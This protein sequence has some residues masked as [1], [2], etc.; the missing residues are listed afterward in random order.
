MVNGEWAIR[1]EKSVN[2]RKGGA[3][4]EGEYVLR[5]QINYLTNVNSYVSS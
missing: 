5:A 2:G 3:G 4:C 1:N